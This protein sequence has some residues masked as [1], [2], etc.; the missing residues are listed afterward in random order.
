MLWVLKG[1]AQWDGSFEHA[2]NMLRLF[3]WA[4]QKYVKTDG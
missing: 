3:F 2:K 1:T 4:R